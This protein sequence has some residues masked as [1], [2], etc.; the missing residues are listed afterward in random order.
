MARRRTTSRRNPEVRTVA[1][2]KDRPANREY[3]T[4]LALCCATFIVYWPSLNG[5]LVWDD[6]GHVTK[7]T[8]QSMRG[9]WRIWFDLGATQQYYPLLHSAFWIEHHLWGDA[10]LG[11][12]LVNVAWHALA[13]CLV[14]A[15]V[16]R[17]E[18]PGAWLAGVGLALHDR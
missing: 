3:A 13:A 17:L 2:E 5:G 1:V 8:L 10:V 4:W 6:N 16:R 15:I 14:V 7:P 18:L 11:Y 9:L 12:H